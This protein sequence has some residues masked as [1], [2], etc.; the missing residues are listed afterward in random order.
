[1]NNVFGSIKPEKLDRP[2]LIRVMQLR[3]FRQMTPEQ[4]VALADRA[5]AEFGRNGAMR[6]IFDFTPA[7]KKIYAYFRDERT[8]RK[9]FFEGNLMLMARTR[10]FQWM[11]DYE[12]LSEVDRV[13]LMR[14]VTA[15]MKYWE[16]IYMDFLHA[17]ELPIPSMAELIREFEKMIDDFKIGATPEEIVRIDTFKRRMNT[18]IVAGEVGGAVK[19]LSDNVSS[20]VSNALGTFLQPSKK[21][22]KKTE[23]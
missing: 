12:I 6:P 14:N 21:N 1:M 11:N 10:Y 7:E 18:A 5:E 16:T 23:K 3:D 8:A 9:S 17:A 20:A 4:V 13:E 15:E 19:N 2:T 22:E